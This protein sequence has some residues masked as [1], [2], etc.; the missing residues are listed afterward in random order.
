MRECYKSLS[1]I[2]V[3]GSVVSIIQ[4]EHSKFQK[5]N[6]IFFSRKFILCVLLVFQ[7]VKCSCLLTRTV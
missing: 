4:S 3:I 7:N 6:G 5:E 1:D 2:D